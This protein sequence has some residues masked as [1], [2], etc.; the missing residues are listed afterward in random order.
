MNG[1]AARRASLMQGLVLGL[2]LGLGACGHRQPFDADSG[3]D[4]GANFT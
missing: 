1:G 4:G 2:T 3:A